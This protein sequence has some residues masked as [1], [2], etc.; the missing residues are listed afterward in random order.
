MKI[1]LTKDE[2]KDVLAHLENTNQ[3]FC[4]MPDGRFITREDCKESLNK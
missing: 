3:G 1:L 4:F 2:A